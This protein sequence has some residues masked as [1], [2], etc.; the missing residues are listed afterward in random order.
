MFA[1]P[2]TGAMANENCGLRAHPT[3]L[4]GLWWR[5]NEVIIMTDRMQKYGLGILLFLLII[6]LLLLI[7]TLI[8][9]P[10]NRAALIGKYQ[11][12]Y[13]GIGKKSDQTKNVY[14]D[15]FHSLELRSDGSFIY[16]YEPLKG[17]EYVFGDTW[18]YERKAFGPLITFDR[19]EMAKLNE[20]FRDEPGQFSSVTISIKKLSGRRIGISIDRDVGF[21]LIKKR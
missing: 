15:G 13:V 10:I 9:P 3:R 7:R 2:L 8:F 5:W 6:I 17:E 12:G 19:I 4:K 20:E 14:N 16:R 18:R 1:V 11:G 21:Y